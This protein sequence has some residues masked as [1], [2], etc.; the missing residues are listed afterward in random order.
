[1]IRTKG[2]REQARGEAVR[3][4]RQVLVEIRKLQNTPMK[5]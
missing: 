5:N 2:N 1:M 4:M 3:H